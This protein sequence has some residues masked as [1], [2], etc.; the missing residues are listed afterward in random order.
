MGRHWQIFAAPGDEDVP[1]VA[2]PSP[3]V[4][5]RWVRVPAEHWLLI[6]DVAKALDQEL[7]GALA[8][9]SGGSDPNEDA[10]VDLSHQ[11]LERLSGFISNVAN[12]ILKRPP[13]TTEATTDIHDDFVTAEHDRMVNDV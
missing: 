12:E 8:W 1:L 9:A 6:L 11:E 10:S 4:S 3:W 5:D 2:R 7:G 13:L